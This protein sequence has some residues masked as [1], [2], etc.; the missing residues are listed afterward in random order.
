MYTI[1]I[2]NFRT[3]TPKFLA[4]NKCEVVFSYSYWTLVYETSSSHLSITNYYKNDSEIFCKL[5]ISPYGFCNKA[6]GY[7]CDCRYSFP[8]CKE[9]DYNALCNVIVAL[10]EEIEKK[11]GTCSAVC[12]SKDK[13]SFLQK[14]IF[15]NR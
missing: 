6:Y 3:I 1:D 14:L 13:L 9:N 12:K 11:S 10:F 5:E 4:R 2:S 8:R 15:L 7:E